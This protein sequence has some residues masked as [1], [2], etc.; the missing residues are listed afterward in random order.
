MPYILQA[1]RPAFDAII[2]SLDVLDFGTASLKTLLDQMADKYAKAQG[3]NYAAYNKMMGMLICATLELERRTGVTSTDTEE[4]LFGGPADTSMHT[5]ENILRMID[6]L[7]LADMVAGDMNYCVTRLCHNI[8][9]GFD[10]GILRQA[11]TED[12]LYTLSC[13]IRE[14]YDGIIGPYEDTKIEA[15]GPVSEIG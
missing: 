15:N 13:V 7:P 5:Y 4:D 3:G 14:Y 10:A 8:L 2:D 9:R 1:N 6:Q 11:A 12:V